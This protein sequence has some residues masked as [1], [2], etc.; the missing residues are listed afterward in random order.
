MTHT[1]NLPESDKHAV[2]QLRGRTE[3]NMMEH[4]GKDVNRNAII[5]YSFITVITLPVEA[6]SRPPQSPVLLEVSAC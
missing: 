1:C 5:I 4:S 2:Q 6:D 3:R